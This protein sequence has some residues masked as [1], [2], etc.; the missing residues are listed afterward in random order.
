[1]FEVLAAETTWNNCQVGG[2]PTL[3]C[4]EV[5]FE[6]VVFFMSSLVIVVLFI[7]FIIGSFTYLTS[8]GNPEKLKKAQG[9]L[10]YAL[11]GFVLFIGAFLILKTIDV[12]FLGG[13]GNLFQF[14]IGL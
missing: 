14:K 1:M 7:M 13:K 4:L 2:V 3:K 12:L 5:V 10:K 11:I 9:T 6:R 8:L